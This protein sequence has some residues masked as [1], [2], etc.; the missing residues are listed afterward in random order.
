M[1]GYVVA[2]LSLAAL[3]L[4]TYVRQ[5]RAQRRRRDLLPGAAWIPP[6]RLH[7]DLPDEAFALAPM[8]CGH[9]RR[10]LAAWHIDSPA[11]DRAAIEYAFDSGF[12]ERR[13]THAYRIVLRAID[14]VRGPA[15][16]T[17]DEVLAARA[18][19]TAVCEARCGPW[20]VLSSSGG[21]ARAFETMPVSWWEEQPAERNFEI[22][23]G[24]L[25]AYERGAMDEFTLP[26]L[27][28]ALDALA[29]RVSEAR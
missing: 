25:A 9:S 12:G 24:L 29:R 1:I 28:Q 15:L 16:A 23:P 14:E 5:R 2:L 18:A 27:M 10:V 13:R 11:G 6:E 21:D 22:R 20:R 17:R 7:V 3:A 8:T 26:D 19:L 4:A